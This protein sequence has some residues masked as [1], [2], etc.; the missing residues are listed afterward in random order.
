MY[1]LNVHSHAGVFIL[2]KQMPAVP[3]V[4]AITIAC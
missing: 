3:A 1:W 2:F 4:A